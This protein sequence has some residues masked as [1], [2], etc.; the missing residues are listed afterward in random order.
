VSVIVGVHNGEAFI[1]RTI[2]SALAQTLDDIEIVV[3][4]DGSTD[5]TGDIVEGFVSRD[6]RVRLVRSPQGGAGHARNVAVE[7]ARSGLIAVLDADDL[8]R[9]DKLELQL[10]AL[11]DGPDRTA[12][13]GCLA[14]TIDTDDLIMAALQPFSAQVM[15]VLAGYA[16]L[17]VVLSPLPWCGSLPLFDRA[18]FLRVGGYDTSLTVYEDYELML[19]LAERYQ[20]I[21]LPE[22]LVGYRRYPQSRSTDAA[23]NLA[24]ET[25]VL[26]DLVQRNRWIPPE[27]VRRRRANGHVYTSATCLEAGDLMGAL[28]GGVRAIACDPAVVLQD[29]GT[30]ALVKLIRGRHSQASI[31]SLVFP[32]DL[33]RFLAQT[34]DSPSLRR[35]VFECIDWNRY[36]ASRRTE[37]TH[38]FTVLR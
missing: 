1:E 31:T 18:A 22:F 14:V 25:A 9:P 13:V 37:L 17:P 19:R 29:E 15:D 8:W 30:R 38:R 2:N 20:I 7:H 11:R 6:R 35:R 33:D 32:D 10:A 4:D 28:M 3:A 23:S 27:V 21:A 36:V 24:T 12:A 5:G 26:S 16:L 34:I